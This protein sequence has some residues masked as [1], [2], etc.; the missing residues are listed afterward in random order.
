MKTH[1][2]L[3]RLFSMLD[4]SVLNLN[5]ELAMS[6][7]MPYFETVE[8]IDDGE[9]QISDGKQWAPVYIQFTR[10]AVQRLEDRFSG[11]NAWLN[12]K[13]LRYLPKKLREVKNQYKDLLLSLRTG[14][15][16]KVDYESFLADIA[17]EISKVDAEFRTYSR[18]KRTG[19]NGLTRA[20]L[21]MR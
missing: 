18:K 9:V 3:L 13:S 11:I 14:G 20:S 8:D 17:R 21:G 5:K 2:I 16:V 7:V 10:H 19:Q 1:G 6:Q 12:G 15:C 4:T